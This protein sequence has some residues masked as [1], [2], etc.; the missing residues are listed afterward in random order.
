M[1]PKVSRSASGSS[2]GSSATHLSSS[3]SDQT[4]GAACPTAAVGLPQVLRSSEEVAP[5]RRARRP[6]ADSSV[7]WEHLTAASFAAG[8]SKKRRTYGASD[9]TRS[10]R[11]TIAEMHSVFLDTLNVTMRTRPPLLFCL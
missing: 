4:E 9:C 7:D 5:R 8:V 3:L 10:C 11:R 6:F 2:S 1:P